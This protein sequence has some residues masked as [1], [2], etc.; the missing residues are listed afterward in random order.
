[1][2]PITF[3]IVAFVAFLAG[4]A[5]S[6]FI[7]NGTAKELNSQLTAAA[8]QYNTAKSALTESEAHLADAQNSIATLETNLTAANQFTN[9]LEEHIDRM[10][11]REATLKDEFSTLEETCN[12]RTK[13]LSLAKTE[14]ASLKKG[15]ASKT[16]KTPQKSTKSVS[17]KKVAEKNQQ[18]PSQLT[19]RVSL[20]APAKKGSAASH[21]T[22]R[23]SLKAPARST[24]E[25]ISKKTTPVRP[26][27]PRS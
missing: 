13:A 24:G 3:S 25:K 10:E 12:E 21:L 1:M 16:S 22:Q 26:P 9:E 5:L 11:V 23:V 27:K 14:L 20:K 2:D 19:Q 7:M 4:L 15:N 18:A 17:D 8:D 6:Y